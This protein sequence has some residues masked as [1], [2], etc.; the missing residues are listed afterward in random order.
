MDKQNGSM[1]VGKTPT[2]RLLADFDACDSVAEQLY[3]K[4]QHSR[5]KRKGP[6]RLIVAA[7]K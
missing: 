1:P 6:S 3:R 2:S 4:K 5:L 7:K